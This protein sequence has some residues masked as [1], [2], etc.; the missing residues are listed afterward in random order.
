MRIGIQ[1]KVCGLLTG[2]LVLAVGGSTWVSTSRSSRT[3]EALG[4]RSAQ[5]LRDSAV[6]R[7]RGVFASLETGTKGS[8]ERGEMD[9]FEDLLVDLGAI[10]GVVEVGLADAEGTIIYASRESSVKTR[11]APDVLQKAAASSEPVGIPRGNQITVIQAHRFRSECLGCH[12]RAKPEALAGVLYLRYSLADAERAQ[13]ET[14]AF[15]SEA[16]RASIQAAMT[17][18]LMSLVLATLG[19][20]LLYAWLVTRR[21]RRFVELLKSMAQGE[22]DLS[23]RLPLGYVDCSRVIGC[24][25][26][27]CA[28]FGKREA[29][30][31]RVG[32]MQLIRENIQCPAV[33]SGEITDCST[34]EVFRAAERDEIDELAN[35][36]NIF[37]D[38]IRYMVE[39]VKGSAA[40]MAA[41]SQQL[42]ATTTQ[43]GASNEEVSQ[44]TQALA[45]SGEEMGATVHEVA[46]NAVG[47]AQAAD[48]ARG[49]ASEAADKVRETGAALERIAEVVTGAGHVVEGLSSEA[50]KIDVVIRTIEDI[51]DQTNLLALNAA[52]EAARAGEHGRGFAVVADEVRKLAE[53]TVK[54]TQEIAQTIDGIQGKTRRAVEAMG[55]G[56]SAVEQG[57]ALGREAAGAM[58]EVEGDV[59]HAA[60]QVEQIAAATEELTATI[61]N[62]AMNLDQIAQGVGENTRAGEELARTAETVA[63]KADELRGLTDRFR[64]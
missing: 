33:L 31:S 40:E 45:A 64:T 23:K 18:G 53:K 16:R 43:I 8:V 63:R 57:K 4:E 19:T 20:W 10:E 29:C 59:S 9:R 13:K 61:E 15:V 49:R 41:V 58:A 28:S 11:I 42:S 12:R 56:V 38:K 21:T 7:A 52:I 46:R 39:R 35:W 30:W 51:A 5:A 37:A 44:Q 14:M 55:E 32:S 54:A 27:Q 6:A 24:G 36:F 47:V 17:T 50:E 60:A 3:L 62:L 48:R 26:E 1:L 34:C 2:L 22:G 25:H